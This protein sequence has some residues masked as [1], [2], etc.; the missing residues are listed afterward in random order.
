MLC[1]AVSALS[2]R[3]GDTNQKI[4]QFTAWFFLN[5]SFDYY[6]HQTYETLGCETYTTILIPRTSPIIG[7]CLYIN[8]W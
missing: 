2:T 7:H 1:G 8:I 5:L 3:L 4:K 6:V